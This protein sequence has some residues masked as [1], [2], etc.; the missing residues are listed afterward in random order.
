ILDYV[1]KTNSAGWLPPEDRFS[2]PFMLAYK[3]EIVEYLARVRGPGST[4]AYKP[5]PRVTGEATQIVVTEYDIPPGH[6]PGT[7][8]A[9]NGSDWSLGT[10][11]KVESRAAHDAV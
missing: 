3:D 11:S 9:D 7:V 1:L 2:M 6:R 4:L 10:P 8:V 5:F